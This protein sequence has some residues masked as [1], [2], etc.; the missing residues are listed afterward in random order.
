[1]TPCQDFLFVTADSGLS[2]RLGS[3]CAKAGF[4]A[5]SAAT[6][7][8]ALEAFDRARF[9]GIFVDIDG[10]GLK[11]LQ[12]LEW[13]KGRGTFAALAVFAPSPSPEK[14]AAAL[15][16][17]AVECLGSVECGDDALLTR[18]LGHVL[19]RFAAERVFKVHET[20]AADGTRLSWVGEAPAV[21]YALEKA[22]ACAA[23]RAPALIR[24]APGA[25][26]GRLARLIA[27][28]A[29]G[30]EVWFH[31]DS[32]ERD[33][34]KMG[35]SNAIESLCADGGGTLCVAEIGNLN[36]DVQEALSELIRGRGLDRGG[37]VLYPDVKLVA[38]SSSDL[39]LLVR[40]GRFRRDLHMA[41]CRDV[42]SVPSLAER[43]GD[44]P[45]LAADF[46]ENEFSA[47]SVRYLTDDAL[48]VL[49]SHDWPGNV[50]ELK[51]L[52][53]HAAA[54]GRNAV[55]K[56]KDLP[57]AILEK[58]F[59]VPGAGDEDWHE[60]PYVDA[61]RI[62]LNKFNREY[63]SELLSRAHNNLTVA[64]ERAGMDRSNFKKIIKKFFPDE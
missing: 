34:Q 32:A 23:T 48:A 11:G 6:F 43:K 59:Y 20:S 54:A 41:L 30:R 28:R 51:N 64:A 31:P 58:G 24:G 18:R 40:G 14:F 26:T 46:L 15:A 1:M 29:G 35:F 22:L 53:R 13:M 61:K 60:K 47:G 17:G 7:D 16:L 33:D 57:A 27:A 5:S 19:K 55:I 9:R 25:G 2:S 52:V 39:E 37:S 56:A 12:I 62:A 50:A 63:I 42:V 21:R 8:D 3:V 49:S 36:P 4:T 44:I 38:T 10:E 45:F